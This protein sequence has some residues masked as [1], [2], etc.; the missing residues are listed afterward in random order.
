MPV[1][2]LLCTD[3]QSWTANS[4]EVDKL[5]ERK[6]KLCKS[7]S[8]SITQVSYWI[9]L[10]VYVNNPSPVSLNQMKQLLSN[11][12]PMQALY[13]YYLQERLSEDDPCIYLYTYTLA[14]IGTTF[15]YNR[16]HV[17]A[18]GVLGQCLV[19]SCKKCLGAGSRCIG[20][21]KLVGCQTSQLRRKVSYSLTIVFH[22]CGWLQ[23]IVYKSVETG[24]TR[25]VMQCLF[26]LA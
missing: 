19:Y 15:F 2:Y 9:G 14:C 21:C 6:V 26:L 12:S 20:N 4:I 23:T 1:L 8:Q 24:G 22:L 10:C 7:V 18:Q 25:E 5:E 3:T 17:S 11:V 16:R 13:I